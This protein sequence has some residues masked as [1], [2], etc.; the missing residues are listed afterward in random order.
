MHSESNGLGRQHFGPFNLPFH[1]SNPMRNDE[2]VI[3]LSVKRRVAGI[4]DILL[5]RLM[6]PCFFVSSNATPAGI[7][8]H[9]YRR[10]S[11]IT[12]SL[13]QRLSSS[14]EITSSICILTANFAAGCTS[15][16]SRFLS[17]SWTILLTLL[18][19]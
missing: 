13:E 12:V 17:V 6:F 9:R 16:S 8:S 19:L 3:C 18:R 1:A 15:S 10:T 7:F 14:T 5:K 4:H 2:H 11:L